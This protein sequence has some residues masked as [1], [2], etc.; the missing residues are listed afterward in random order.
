MLFTF[1]GIL[2]TV[3]GFIVGLSVLAIENFNIIRTF[4]HI[5]ALILTAL[6]ILLGVLL[7]FFGFML[8]IMIEI[9][10]RVDKK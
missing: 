3:A 7:F 6:L 1:L 2:L 8:S 5:P 10:N 4:N 9:K